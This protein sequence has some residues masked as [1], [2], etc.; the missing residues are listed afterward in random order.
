MQEKAARAA[1]EERIA[2]RAAKD[3]FQIFH[4]LVP[5]VSDTT[6]ST[7]IPSSTQRISNAQINAELAEE[8]LKLIDER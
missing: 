4:R 7:L 5:K 1:K 8:H 3:E 6:C 2:A